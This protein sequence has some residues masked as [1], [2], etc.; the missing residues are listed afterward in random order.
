MVRA[1]RLGAPCAACARACACARAGRGQRCGPVARTRVRGQ[2]GAGRAHRGKA[3]E[4][5][6]AALVACGSGAEEGEGEG[7]REGKRK[8]RKR[9]E[10]WKKGKEGEKRK[11][12]GEKERE[13]ECAGAD[14]GGRSRVGDQ[15]PSGA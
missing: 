14:R 9:K 5:G 1:S 10:K 6:R 15:P 11:R 7:K 2:A 4:P 3:G 12:E 13:S 8:E